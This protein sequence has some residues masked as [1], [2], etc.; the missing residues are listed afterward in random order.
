MKKTKVYTI[1]KNKGTLHE[2]D[3]KS[4][5][6][7][8]DVIH[9]LYYS[10]NNIW[11]SNARGRLILSVTDSADDF[12]LKF[13]FDDEFH[14]KLNLSTLEHDRAAYMFVILKHIQKIHKMHRIKFK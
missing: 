4:Y 3:I 7:K 13:E 12:D 5:K 9:E 2:Y 11:S 10:K 14:N 6:K 1:T 8:Q